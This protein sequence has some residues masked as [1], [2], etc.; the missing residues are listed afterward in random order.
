MKKFTL[1][2]VL[3]VVW[4]WPMEFGI[5]TE[6]QDLDAGKSPAAASKSPQEQKKTGK[7]AAVQPH[8]KKKKDAKK[9]EDCGCETT[10]FGEPVT[11]QVPKPVQGKPGSTERKQTVKSKGKNVDD[12]KTATKSDLKE[13]ALQKSEKPPETS[14]D[15]NQ[16]K[17]PTVQPS[18]K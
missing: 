17:T 5:G 2:L 8:G 12:S 3:L 1:I 14:G 10:L 15:A 16:S 13:G 4:S 7:D 9:D 18:A 11:P 6:S